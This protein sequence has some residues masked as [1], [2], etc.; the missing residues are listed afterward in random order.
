MNKNE[1]N[2]IKDIT[3]IL[4]NYYQSGKKTFDLFQTINSVNEMIKTLENKSHISEILDE[5]SAEL[6]GLTTESLG[7]EEAIAN[8][9]NTNLI[10]ECMFNYIDEVEKKIFSSFLTKY[11]FDFRIKKIINE[12]GTI[13]CF[14]KIIIVTYEGNDVESV[15]GQE[16]S[17]SNFLQTKLRDYTEDFE[18]VDQYIDIYSNILDITGFGVLK[19]GYRKVIIEDNYSKDDLICD[20]WIKLQELIGKE[21]CIALMECFPV[22]ESKKERLTE[23]IIKPII[24][25]LNS[26]KDYINSEYKKVSVNGRVYY[27]AGVY[28]FEDNVSNFDNYI[29]K[30]ASY[31]FLDEASLLDNYLLNN[32]TMLTDDIIRKKFSDLS[33]EL[34][35]ELLSLNQNKFSNICI[36]YIILADPTENIFN[37]EGVLHFTPSVVINSIY[38][39]TKS[40]LIYNYEFQ[41]YQKATLSILQ[42]MSELRDVETAYHQARVTIYTKIIA[43]SIRKKNEEGTLEDFLTQNGIRGDTDYGLIDKE[44]IRDLLFSAS[45]HDI[46]KIGIDD[47]IL[48]SPERLNDNE[49]DAIKLHTIYGKQSLSTF[50]RM[51]DKKTF[52]TLASSIAEHHHERWD[53][54]GYPNG[55]TGFDIPL[56][57]RILAVADVYDALRRKRTYKNSLS[58]EEAIR[59]ITEEKGKHFDPV[60]TDIFL[61]QSHVINE[62]YGLIKK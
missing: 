12:Y 38:K 30:L 29:R 52:L 44:Y 31:G 39:T 20:L 10:Y 28:S 51:N 14:K 13:N 9:R 3:A 46:G 8:F 1:S 59:I 25:S 60:I 6:V 57:S 35:N 7:K 41:E 21:K 43:D 49:Y 19:T 2:L 22:F 24:K 55:K 58:H 11:K 37:E 23:R 56:S 34:L 15:Y 32:I 54:K 5:V 45:L 53:G 42:R 47:A 48:K 62:T 17:F 26:S 50:L 16:Y 18:A 4:R 40:I 61:E 36:G 27:G 33:P